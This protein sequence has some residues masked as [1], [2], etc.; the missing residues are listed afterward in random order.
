[1]ALSVIWRSGCTYNGVRFHSMRNASL[2]RKMSFEYCY[3]RRRFNDLEK[4]AGSVKM[5]HVFHRHS[6]GENVKSFVLST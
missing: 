1:M 4:T 2:R 6:Q 5:G 3:N